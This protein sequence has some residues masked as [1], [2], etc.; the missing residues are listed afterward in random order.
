M[1]LIASSL[2]A[3]SLALWLAPVWLSAE[4]L[5][6]RLRPAHTWHAPLCSHARTPARGGR[7]TQHWASAPNLCCAPAFSALRVRFV[8]VSSA[9]PI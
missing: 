6:T 3:P 9:E 4:V 2:N 8:S 1:D 7:T 5:A